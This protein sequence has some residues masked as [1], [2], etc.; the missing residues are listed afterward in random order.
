MLKRFNHF[1]SIEGDAWFTGF[2]EHSNF[3]FQLGYYTN[4]NDMR[5]IICACC[6]ADSRTN[7]CGRSG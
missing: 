2:G 6:N 4:F 3:G 7:G 1:C 5:S